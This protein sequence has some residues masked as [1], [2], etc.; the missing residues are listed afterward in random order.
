MRYLISVSYDGSK[1]NGF[2]KLNN[3]LTIQGELERVLSII[4]KNEV[5]VKGSGRTDRGVH[6]INQKCHFDLDINL[7][8]TKLIQTINDRVNNAIHINDC[9]IVNDNFHARFDV[10][11]K[12]YIYIINTGNYDPLINDYTYNLNRKLN[13][14]LMKKAAKLFCGEHSLQNFVSGKRDN[15]NCIIDGIKFSSYNNQ[16]Y[17]KFIGKSFYRYMVR[18][19]VGSLI[20][21]GLGKISISKMEEL[22]NNSVIEV[23]YSTAPAS[24]LYLENVEY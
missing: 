13:I 10:K 3:K 8:P 24:G 17:I 2:Q 16:L 18:N 6:A 19:I 1:F 20:Y 15:Y 7:D 11:R 14:R 23:P 21:V 5:F 22:I 9:K 12:T 4:N